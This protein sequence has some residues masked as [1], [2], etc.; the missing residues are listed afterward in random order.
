MEYRVD[1]L[2]L[3]IQYIIFKLI[4]V[5]AAKSVGA[6][7]KQSVRFQSETRRSRQGEETGSA[8]TPSGV[9][10][11]NKL[12]AIYF[13]WEK[14]IDSAAAKKGSFFLSQHLNADHQ[15]SKAFERGIFESLT[16]VETSFKKIRAFAFLS[17]S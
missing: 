1:Q 9:E 13:V 3:N 11:H 7:L 10:L 8:R 16:L 12:E 4:Y 17:L 2:L 6:G 15:L 5:V 14:I